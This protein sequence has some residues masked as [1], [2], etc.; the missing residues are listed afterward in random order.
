MRRV[1]LLTYIGVGLACFSGC[2][3]WHRKHLARA[4]YTADACGCGETVSGSF[5][6]M[7]VAT[8]Q[9]IQGAPTKVIP[10]SPPATGIPGPPG[11]PIMPT[12]RS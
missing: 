3:H 10:L 1:V 12:P 2:H 11:G 9:V 7:P 5:D 4:C 6:S 8:S